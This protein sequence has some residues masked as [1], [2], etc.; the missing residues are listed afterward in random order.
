MVRSKNLSTEKRAQ[1]KALREQGMSQNQISKALKV[2][3]SVVCRTLARIKELGN[4][5]SRKRSGR[6]RVTSPLTERKIRR[7]SVANPTWSAKTI[8]IETRTRA[9]VRTVRRRLLVDFNLASRS[10]A[11]KSLLSAKNIRD[12]IQF[13]KKYKNWTKEQWKNVLFSDESTFSQYTSYVRHVRRPVNQRYNMRYVVPTVKHAPTTMIWGSFGARGRGGIWFM[14]K[15]TTI[16]GPVYLDVLKDKL[17]PHMNILNCTIFQHDGAP[18][19]RTKAVKQWLDDQGIEVLGPWPGSS[20]DLN[21]IEN[22]WT[23]MK[24]KVSLMKPTSEKELIA[25]IKE[26][27]TTRITPQYC[28][29][30]ACS[31]P[32]RIKAVLAAKGRHSKY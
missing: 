3:Q 31:M 13:C 7:S 14:P 29:T 10:P 22:L 30:L 6:P 21:P 9:S 28:E 26:V 32:D 16:N 24:E 8:A 25:A 4:F 15:N 23:S 17:D 1:I 18:C 19:H 5:T 12:R 27:W 20:P 2:S 11:K